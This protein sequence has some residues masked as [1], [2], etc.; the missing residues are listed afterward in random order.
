M[1]VGIATECR[2][3][4]SIAARTASWNRGVTISV[5]GIIFGKPY[6][7]QLSV[8]PLHCVSEVPVAPE[9][10]RFFQGAIRS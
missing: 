5:A 8:T 1:I 6:S 10:F 2:L 4:Q 3:W 7:I 9:N